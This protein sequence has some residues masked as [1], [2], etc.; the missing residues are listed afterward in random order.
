MARSI[1]YLSQN[2]RALGPG[3]IALILFM[4][5]SWGLNQVAI[6]LV[7]PE[8][9]P[10]MQGAIRS[11]CGLLVI[12][13][14]AWWRGIK[15]FE[16]DGTLRDGLFIGFVFGCEFL[17]IYPGLALTTA[18]RAVVFLYTAPFFMAFGS[19]RFLGE[20]LTRIQWSGLA[21]SFAGVALAIGVPQPDVD[22]RVLIGD[23]MMVGGGVCW[24]T[25]VLLIKTTS[26]RNISAEKGLGYQLAGSIPLLAIGS[27]LM[28]EVLAGIPGKLSV[29]LLAY[30]SIWVVGGTFLIWFMMVKIYS[31]S[32][33]SA[34]TFVT[35]LFGVA[36]G[37]FILNEPLSIAFGGAAVLVAAGLYLVNRPA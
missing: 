16:R 26:L 6:K 25:T 5:L 1:P 2:E 17:L 30:Q 4:C 10:L 20:R 34:F 12:V 15:L 19:Y 21:L 31:P 37:Y 11:S 27:W 35:P 7:L 28:G 29:A 18:S 9:P 33:L 13:L 14:V 22:A 3:A 32:K 24:A 8:I 23:L 36:A